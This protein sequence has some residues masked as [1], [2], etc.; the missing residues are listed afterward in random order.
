MTP[1]IKTISNK[2]IN[3]RLTGFLIFFCLFYPSIFS[4]DNFITGPCPASFDVSIQG[5]KSTYSL[6]ENISCTVNY[7]LRNSWE[8]LSCNQ[9][10]VIGLVIGDHNVYIGNSNCIY[11]G[12][13]NVCPLE[14]QGTASLIWKIPPYTGTF[15]IIAAN[16]YLNNSLEALVIFPQNAS[17]SKN[18]AI[19]TVSA[20]NTTPSPPSVTLNPTEVTQNPS[21]ITPVTVP[22]IHSFI[23]NSNSIKKGDSTLLSWEVSDAT[24]ILISPDI[25]QV[26]S[27]GT[28]AIKPSST[29]TYTLTAKNASGSTTKTTKVT[30]TTATTIDPLIPFLIIIFSLALLTAITFYVNS[31]LKIMKLRNVLKEK[32]FAEYDGKWITQKEYEIIKAEEERK[33]NL[34]QNVEDCINGCNPPRRYSKESEYQAILHH[35]LAQTLKIGFPNINPTWERQIETERPD[36]VVDHVAIEVKGPTTNSDLDTLEDKCE[37]YTKHWNTI[38]F[39]LFAPEYN[40]EK[41]SKIKNQIESNPN[42]KRFTIHFMPKPIQQINNV[43]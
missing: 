23:V 11:D 4:A 22:V 39:V 19:V 18:L 6:G 28:S 17:T 42:Y 14:T 30:V 16:Y 13:P 2:P 31:L 3:I 12:T 35:S 36:I 32:G 27:S 37:R 8:C 43:Q 15:R 41:Y 9:Q 10:I 7:S 34:L 26:N 24:Q 21:T 33:R 1:I 38:I 29:T 25:G 20:S 40:P 5:V